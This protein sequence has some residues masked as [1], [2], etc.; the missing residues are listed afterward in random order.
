MT[1]YDT[2]C[3]SHKFPLTNFHGILNCCS[4][5]TFYLHQQWT[6]TNNSHY[7]VLIWPSVIVNDGQGSIFVLTPVLIQPAFVKHLYFWSSSDQPVWIISAKYCDFWISDQVNQN[8]PFSSDK[9]PPTEV[10]ENIQVLSLLLQGNLPENHIHK[11]Y[12]QSNWS[13]LGWQPPP[14]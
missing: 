4:P 12:L 13:K 1:V 5:F 9:S 3:V 2:F 8:N 14:P 10:E 11:K 7:I 6:F